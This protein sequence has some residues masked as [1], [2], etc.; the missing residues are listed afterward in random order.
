ML[1]GLLRYLR[2]SEPGRFQPMNSNW[3]LVD[4]LPELI[5]GSD[6]AE[7]RGERVRDKQRKRERLAE[8]AQED[9]LAWMRTAGI[10]V[11]AAPAWAER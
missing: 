9:F 1:G 8:R 4:P 6:G 3:G 5:R 10:G 2:E 11:P 7:P